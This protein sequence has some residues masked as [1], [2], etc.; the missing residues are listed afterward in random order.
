MNCSYRNGGSGTHEELE[1]PTNS[2][3]NTISKLLDS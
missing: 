2:P 1:D 3:R